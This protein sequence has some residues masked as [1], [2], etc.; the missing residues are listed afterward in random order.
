[1]EK[2]GVE[3]WDDVILTVFLFSGYKRF[4]LTSENLNQHME[5]TESSPDGDKSNQKMKESKVSRII[6]MITNKL[7]DIIWVVNCILF[8]FVTPLL[9]E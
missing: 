2:V 1:M 5:L 7:Y 6:I 3:V 9:H 4:N 8:T